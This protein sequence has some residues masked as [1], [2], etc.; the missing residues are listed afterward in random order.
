[1]TVMRVSRLDTRSSRLSSRS[2]TSSSRV[3]TLSSRVSTLASRVSRLASRASSWSSRVSTLSSRVSA[4]SSRVST[5]SSRVST[6]TRCFYAVQQHVHAVQPRV[7]AVE[8]P[9]NLVESFINLVESGINLVES[10][11]NLVESRVNAV[12]TRIDQEE[13]CANDRQDRQNSAPINVETPSAKVRA[14]HTGSPPRWIGSPGLLSQLIR[15]SGAIDR[16]TVGASASSADDIAAVQV[17]PLLQSRRTLPVS[18]AVCARQEYQLSRPHLRLTP[19]PSGQRASACHAFFL[20]R[21]VDDG[22]DVCPVCGRCVDFT[23]MFRPASIL[24]IV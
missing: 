9:V 14:R 16:G 22:L 3:S 11:I 20:K 2:V 18:Q 8:S 10:G 24:R 15:T 23:A 12:Q 1:M 21:F 7:Y 17:L 4:L 13:H 5:L 19:D 6:R